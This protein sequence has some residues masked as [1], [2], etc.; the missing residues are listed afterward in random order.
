MTT[1]RG[2][3]VTA[4]VVAQR[5]NLPRAALDRR[6][7]R[8]RARGLIHGNYLSRAHGPPYV[9]RW[10][11]ILAVPALTLPLGARLPTPSTAERH[12]AMSKA[13]RAGRTLQQIADAHGLTRSRVQQLL[14]TVQSGPRSRVCRRCGAIYQSLAG[15]TDAYCRARRTETRPCSAC[16]A[17]ITRDRGQDRATFRNHQWFCDRRCFGRWLGRRFG[18]GRRRKHNTRLRR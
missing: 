18:G 10:A 6:L 12:A 16:G 2:S 15:R 9:Y 14:S 5:L 13:R 7:A 8:A 3:W 4:L 17:A 1:A 11:D